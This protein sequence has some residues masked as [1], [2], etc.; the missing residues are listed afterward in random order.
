MTLN[1]KRILVTRSAEQAQTLGD[2]LAILGAEPVIVP[3]IEIVPP[4]SYTELDRAIA[5]LADFDYLVLTSVNAVQAFCNRLKAV[6][7]DTDIL[8]KSQIVVVGPKSAAALKVYGLEADM[9]PD[10]YRAEGVVS[11]LKN[12]IADKRVLYP[13]AAR[14][15]DLIIT[16]LGQ[17]GA[18]VIAP[19]AYGS[20]PPA[21]AP[22]LL[23]QAIEQGLDL[24]TFT[25]SSTVDNFVKLLDAEKLKLAQ[26]IPVASIG[27]LTTSTAE[28]LGFN[29][30]VEPDNSTLDEMVEEIA[31]YFAQL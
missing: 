1:G 31:R 22:Q 9:V 13:K 26:K 23:R 15:R 28:K 2:A 30:V 25:A 4:P 5:E 14:A 6:H 20:A 18:E 24:L 7:V 10:D 21:E 8:K 17:S 19:V 27:P 29:V 12:K 16:K 11:L 3:T